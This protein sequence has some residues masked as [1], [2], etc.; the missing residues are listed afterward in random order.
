MSANFN[1]Q[2][3]STEQSEA[4]ITGEDAVTTILEQLE[5]AGIQVESQ[6]RSGY[7]GACRLKKKSG[8]VK[9]DNDPLAY[10]GQDEI[11]PCCGR[12]CGLLV[13]YI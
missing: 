1:C 11:L 8:E 5:S 10:V 2:I 7:C 12:P 3:V 4:V 9:Y 6:C 13:L